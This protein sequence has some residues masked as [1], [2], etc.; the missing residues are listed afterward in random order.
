MGFVPGWCWEKLILGVCLVSGL[1]FGLDWRLRGCR[2]AR[3]A[4][5]SFL[6]R[7]RVH[8][9]VVSLSR[10]HFLLKEVAGR[11]FGFFGTTSAMA[12]NVHTGSS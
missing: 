8:V 6:R 4:A 10:L 11:E 1:E 9:F 5:I 2:R 12:K 3:I 7:P